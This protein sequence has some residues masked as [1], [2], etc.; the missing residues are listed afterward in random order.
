MNKIY[1]Y[2]QELTISGSAL[3]YIINASL[4]FITHTLIMYGKKKTTIHLEQ[5]TQ[6]MIGGTK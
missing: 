5:H 3:A 6:L 4:N 2:A 1:L